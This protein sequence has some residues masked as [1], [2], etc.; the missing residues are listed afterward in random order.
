MYMPIQL[1]NEMILIVLDGNEDKFFELIS[2][3][4]LSTLECGC[5]PHIV[6]YDIQ[7]T[8]SLVFLYSLVQTSAAMF[9]S[10]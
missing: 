3:K 4:S 7:Y 2:L 5:A 8:R 9:R 6:H 1:V 10:C